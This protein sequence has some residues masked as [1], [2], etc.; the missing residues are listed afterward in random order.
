MK[1][2]ELNAI[3]A[4]VTEVRRRFG[5]LPLCRVEP[6]WGSSGIWLPKQIASI[7]LGPNLI[8]TDFPL[9]EP[10]KARLR[11]WHDVFENETPEL[12]WQIPGSL[13]WFDAEGLNVSV[14]ISAELGENAVVEY[15]I[16]GRRGLLFRTGQCVASYPLD[17]TTSGLWAGSED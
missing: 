15:D 8:L 14:E 13:A 10:V 7:A 16:G 2:S 12:C 5:R 17:P 1:R 9:S 6:D 3:L 11:R 4:E